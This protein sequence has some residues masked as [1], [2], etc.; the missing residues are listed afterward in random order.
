MGFR[1]ARALAPRPADP[2]RP[3]AGVLP[4][5]P[6]ECPMS[7]VAVSLDKPFGVWYCVSAY[8]GESGSGTTRGLSCW[9]CQRRRSPVPSRFERAARCSPSPQRPLSGTS[10]EGSNAGEGSA[11]WRA[12][13][14]AR[15]SSRLCLSARC[16]ER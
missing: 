7:R 16:K 5:S 2:G 13:R 3:A 10:A 6:V 14:L 11:G 15:S 9:S 4:G 12:H 8:T 1:T